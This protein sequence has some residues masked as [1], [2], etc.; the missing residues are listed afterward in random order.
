MAKAIPVDE[1]LRT[2][3]EDEKIIG[4]MDFDTVA[5]DTSSQMRVAYKGHPWKKHI[6]VWDADLRVAEEAYSHPDGNAEGFV[7][8]AFVSLTMGL[9]GR[10]KLALHIKAC[11]V[12]I[13]ITAKLDKQAKGG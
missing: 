6:R 13:R 7:G 8:W 10:S 3:P 5:V 1:W 12:L 2:H 4:G 9:H 11:Q